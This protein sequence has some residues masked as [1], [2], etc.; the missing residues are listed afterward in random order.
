MIPVLVF[1][2]NWGKSGKLGP[3]VQNNGHQYTESHPHFTSNE[4]LL[5]YKNN[6]RVDLGN[7]GISR[8][9]RPNTQIHGCVIHSVKVYISHQMKPCSSEKVICLV[10]PSFVYLRIWDKSVKLGPNN[11]NYG[12]QYTKSHQKC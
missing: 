2:E 11:P 8:N 6:L 10:I 7:W 3:I 9:L 1:L 4:A 5:K 12:Q